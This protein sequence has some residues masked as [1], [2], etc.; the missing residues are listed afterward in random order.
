MSNRNE[1]TAKNNGQIQGQEG[2]S[3]E[4]QSRP[5]PLLEREKE[6]VGLSQQVLLLK[7]YLE[8]A[9][10]LRRS[11][12]MTSPE[13]STAFKRLL[14]AFRQ[15][16]ILRGTEFEQG[17]VLFQEAVREGRKEGIF[18][19][20]LRNRGLTMASDLGERETY[21][22]FLNLIVRFAGVQ[23]NKKSSFA[24]ENNV[25]RLLMRIDN[26]ELRALMAAGFCAE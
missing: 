15:L 10:R 24:K 21:T 12:A 16:C 2:S 25:E 23:A 4:V 1:N 7:Q 14:A 13:H 17:F 9:N 5:E 8:E 22:I 26:S 3:V 11:V 6:P 20:G 18:Q 19:A